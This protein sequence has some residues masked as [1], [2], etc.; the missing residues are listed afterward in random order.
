MAKLLA[1][2]DVGRHRRPVMRAP[3][4]CGTKAASWH[5]PPNRIDRFSYMAVARFVTRTLVC[6][7]APMGFEI[8]LQSAFQWAMLDY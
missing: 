3:P 2:G 6:Y 8:Y 7:L 5:C 1:C 4:G